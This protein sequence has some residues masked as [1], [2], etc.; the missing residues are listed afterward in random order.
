MLDSTNHMS[1]SLEHHDGWVLAVV[2]ESARRKQLFAFA[3]GSAK[4][5]CI[6]G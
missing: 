6:Q 3:C 2:L 4:S 5:P 1:A